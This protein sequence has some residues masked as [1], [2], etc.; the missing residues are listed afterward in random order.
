[1]R[2]VRSV[3]EAETVA[4]CFEEL[5][6]LLWRQRHL[7]DALRFKL[8]VEWLLLDRGRMQ[9]LEVATHEIADVLGCVH[10][11]ELTMA[12]RPLQV[13]GTRLGLGPDARLADVV[14]A[15]PEPWN[16]IVADHHIALTAGLA[17][18]EALAAANDEL[19]R[20]ELRATRARLD[21]AMDARVPRSTDGGPRSAAPA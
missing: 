6:R 17:D 2:V 1:M 21:A 8:E 5:A 3:G 4:A 14:A 19:L 13:L 9:W 16:E 18:V 11:E 20:V 10:A 15:A 12:A 7:L